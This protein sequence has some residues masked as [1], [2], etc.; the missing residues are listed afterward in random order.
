MRILLLILQ[1]PPDVNP[2]GTLMA[3]VA[4]GLAAKGHSVSVISAFPHYEKFRIRPEDRGKRLERKREGDLDITR[5]AVFANGKKED[6]KFRLLSYL[7]FAAMSM[8]VSAVRREHYDVML[9]PNGGFFTGI[10]GFLGGGLRGTPFVYN[11]QDLY[12]ETFVA[13]GRLT[14]HRA[15]RWLGRMEQFMYRKAGHITVIT[16]AFRNNLVEKKR[17]PAQKVSVIPNFVDTDVI[18]PLAKQNPFSEEYGLADKFVV[19]HAGNLGYVY[20]L[21]TLLDAAVGLRK[22][23]GILFLIVGN[24]VARPGLEAKARALGL[25]NVRFMDYQPYEMLPFLRAASDVQVSLYRKH[26]AQYSMPSKVYE[27]MASGRPLLA[28]ADPGSD[29][30]NLVAETGCGICVEPENREQLVDAIL[31][32]YRD[33]ALREQMGRRGR[34]I[35]EGRYSKPIV[36]SQYETEL[37][38]VAE[39]RQGY[40]PLFDFGPEIKQ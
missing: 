8:L 26:A 21:D 6:M 35:A 34:R 11:V 5:V 16:P 10:V 37:R 30:W 40:A 19:S 4:E 20:D 22:E 7:S 13:Q 2:T 12:P 1:F 15:I 38:H 36:V 9:C 25:D 28:S 14:S 29:V 33:P 27:I 31:K 3:Q 24:G 32:L 23:K 17:V 39:R 18:R